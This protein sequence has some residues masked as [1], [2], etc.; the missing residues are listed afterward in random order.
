[1]SINKK[2]VIDWH[3]VFSKLDMNIGILTEIEKEEPN[4]YQN[5]RQNGRKKESF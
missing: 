4:L 2:N 1:M 5:S 3:K